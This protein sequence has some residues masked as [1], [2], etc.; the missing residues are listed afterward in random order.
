MLWIA[1][2]LAEKLLSTNQLKWSILEICHHFAHYTYYRLGN[3][4]QTRFHLLKILIALPCFHI[5]IMHF[6]K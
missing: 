6:L 5:T 4:L 1:L 2:L 3:Y